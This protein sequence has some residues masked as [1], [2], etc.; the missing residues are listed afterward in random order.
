MSD[1][2]HRIGDERRQQARSANASAPK[3]TS[4]SV[5]SPS[6]DPREGVHERHLDARPERPGDADQ[7]GAAAEGHDLDRVERVDRGQRGP[8]HGEPDQEQGDP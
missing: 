5:P 3:T 4:R 7:A 8:D 2:R 6:G 1:Q